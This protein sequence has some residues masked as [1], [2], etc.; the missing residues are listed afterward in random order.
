MEL[1]ILAIRT[2]VLLLRVELED[3]ELRSLTVKLKKR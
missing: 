1:V 3:S 2:I